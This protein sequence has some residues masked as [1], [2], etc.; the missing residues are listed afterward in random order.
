MHE[1]LTKSFWK[2]VKK[3][4]DE[5]LKGPPPEP[6]QPAAPAAEA[7]PAPTQEPAPSAEQQ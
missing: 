3:I 4:Y 7:S 5:A 6:V 2:S 1:V